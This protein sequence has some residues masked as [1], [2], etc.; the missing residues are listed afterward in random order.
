MLEVAIYYSALIVELGILAVAGYLV[1]DAY[2]RSIKPSKYM[3]ATQKLGFIGHA[4]GDGQCI[5]MEEQQEALLRIFHLA[6]YFNLT[7]IWHDLCSIG[8]IKNLEQVFEEISAVVK[9]ANADQ[10]N[11][12]KFDPRYMRKNL[13]KSDSID[14]QDAAD[15]ILYIGQH[16]FSR[17]IGQERCE[18]ISPDWLIAY[19]DEYSEAARSLGLIDREHCSSTEY[20]GIWIAG[21]A[22]LTLAQRILDYSH[23]TVS[24]NIK[25]NG[26]TLIL[27]GEREIWANIDGMPPTTMEKL[28]KIS[29][30]HGNID[31][32]PFV[33]TTGDNLDIVNE[34]KAYMLHL[35]QFNN[36]KLNASDPFIQYESKQECP[37]NRFPHRVYA[38]YDTNETAE[39]TETLMSVDLLRSFSNSNGNEV[40]V[41][42][43]LAQAQ[44]RPNSASTARDAAVRFVQRITAGYYGEKK[45]FVILLHTNNPYIERQTLATQCEV[46]QVLHEYGLIAKAYRIKI[47][48]VGYSCKQ[49][50]VVVH[51]ELGALIAEKWKYVARHEQASLGLKPKR[52]IKDLLFQTRKSDHF[53]VDYPKTTTNAS[54]NCMK[55]VSTRI[56]F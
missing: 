15:L 46:N 35:A 51:S 20:D 19:A 52:D 29:S 21:A 30:N 13:F 16:A 56:C 33:P 39:L 7:N 38:N 36:I 45:T 49:P 12:K 31:T 27:A 26:E 14:V 2:Q 53:V 54:V 6:G 5:S 18:I 40:R 42:D 47:E 43:T 50:L 44:E 10:A 8:D 25:I 3:L 4:R 1:F 23:S 22:R 11:P 48:G 9:C 55:N 17:Q 37:P 24:R 34:G 41:I 32:I 28:L